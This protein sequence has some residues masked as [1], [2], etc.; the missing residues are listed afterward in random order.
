MFFFK[1][2]AHSNH[3]GN[4]GLNE[5]SGS[6]AEPESPKFLPG[7]RESLCLLIRVKCKL[8]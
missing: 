7:L 3:M 1:L 4:L 2:H 5:N 6:R 8:Y